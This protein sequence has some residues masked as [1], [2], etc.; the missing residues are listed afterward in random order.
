VSFTIFLF[1]KYYWFEQIKED[2]T[3]RALVEM[4]RRLKEVIV[5]QILRGKLH[6]LGG[7]GLVGL[8]YFI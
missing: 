5:T 8:R 3:G 7:G 6:L 2:E 4:G 1:V